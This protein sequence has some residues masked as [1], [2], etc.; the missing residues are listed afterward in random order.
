M[1]IYIIYL[2]YCYSDLSAGRCCHHRLQ[3]GAGWRFPGGRHLR[4]AAGARQAGGELRNTQPAGQPERPQGPSGGQPEG[5]QP[6][7]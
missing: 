7:A 2:C 5:R 1:N 3:A 6:H 4:T